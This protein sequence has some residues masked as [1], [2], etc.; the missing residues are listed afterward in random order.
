M[1]DHEFRQ[2][3]A[4]MIRLVVNA[5]TDHQALGA[6]LASVK[7][8]LETL[9]SSITPEPTH[10]LSRPCDRVAIANGR[11]LTNNELQ[12]LNQEDFDLILDQTNHHLR[13]RVNPTKHTPLITTQLEGIGSQRRRVLV[14][15]LERPTRHLCP[16]R[17]PES[18]GEPNG[19]AVAQTIRLFR[20][21]LGRPGRQN[22][23]IRTEANWGETRGS[24]T[25]VYVLDPRWKYLLIQWKSQVGHCVVKE[26]SQVSGRSHCST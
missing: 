14:F 17:M 18:L 11:R 25:S 7:Q 21:A 19:R 2:S 3:V 8:Q 22:P 5:Q 13:F 16:D 23:Y 20:R 24:R 26:E 15:M 10:P 1:S 4:E 12:N 9:Q 6:Q